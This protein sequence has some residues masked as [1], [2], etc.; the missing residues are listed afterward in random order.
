[1]Q[2]HDVWL[3]PVG[4][5]IDLIERIIRKEICGF[6]LAFDWY[7]IVQIYTTFLL[8]KD[9]DA[10]PNILEYALAEPEARDGP[11]LR[12]AGACDLMLHARK[13]PYQNTMNRADIRI[14]RVPVQLSYMLAA[15]LEQRITLSDIFFARKKDK[16]ARRWQVEDISTTREFKNVVLRFAPSSALKNLCLDAG[17]V[18]QKDVLTFGDIDGPLQKAKPNEYAFAPFALAVGN[19]DDW[20]GAWPEVI[21]THINHWGYDEQARRYAYMDVDPCTRG[22]WHHFEKP[23]AGDIDSELACQV[24][25]A[26]WKGYA[27]NM[28][29]IK[30]L[31]DL[32]LSKIGDTPT[33]PAKVMK[34]LMEVLYE[35]E[36]IALEDEHGVPS[37]KKVILETLKEL[38]D[39]DGEAH[40]V[41]VRAKDVLDTRVNKYLAD[42]YDKLIIAGRLHAST[43][44]IGARSSRMSGGQERE[45]KKF[46]K[47]KSINPQGISKK[48][49][50]RAQFPLAFT[51][52]ITKAYGM[53]PQ[54]E[55][56][57]GGDF[58]S[59]EVAI[60]DAYYDDPQLHEDLTSFQPDGS[61]TKIHAVVG[62]LAYPDKTYEEIKASSG[63][64][65]FDFYTRAKSA[66]FALIY[67]G[68]AHT[69]KGRLGI[70][71]GDAE[72]TEKRIM[73]RYKGMGKG[74]KQFERD[75]VGM[76]Q[77]GGQGTKVFWEDPK[78]FV[79]SMLGFPRY[80]TSENEISKKIFEL[81][82][83]LP[84][85]WRNMKMRVQR[86]K[87]E[88]GGDQTAYGAATS[89]L[90]GA[91]FSIQ[92]ANMRAAGNH[93]IQ[94]TGAQLTKI[95]QYRIWELQ[96]RGIGEW[97]VRPLNIHDEVM[98]PRKRG[99]G[100]QIK[101][102]VDDFVEEFKEIIPLLGIDWGQ[103]LANWAG[104]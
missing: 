84:K 30:Y 47:N 64:D 89:A 61:K 2:L 5:T 9:K 94:S 95:L 29:G 25:A 59:F 72:E 103:N 56:L 42:F 35:E 33:A 20:N 74:R 1:V 104:K 41:A 34:Y 63:S 26:K 85:E 67:F 93:V 60:T 38:K 58:M 70:D 77:P 102:I 88:H 53:E 73:H 37:T 11:C 80:F 17:I 83:K 82:T 46:K 86:R 31:R 68:N 16:H 69:L 76:K 55:E 96:P 24:A 54:D 91:A 27:L 75:F 44:I 39:E 51:K 6:N 3:E 92:T 19:P 101:K 43:N 48:K 10:P 4:K 81:A 32:S 79:L 97:Y 50:V 52:G 65:I 23:E 45:G 18:S 22:L 21:Q 100:P 14:R 15:E 36:Q 12:P 7:K 66:L 98:V 40:P 57:D 90:Y 28:K 49:I 8:L 13:G 87:L 78:E 99:L 62:T 71:I